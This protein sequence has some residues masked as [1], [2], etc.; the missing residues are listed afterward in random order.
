[1]Y[2]P[3]SKIWCRYS[4]GCL[5]IILTVT[6]TSL[7]CVFLMAGGHIR[8]ILE[9]PCGSDWSIP[10]HRRSSFSENVEC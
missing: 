5:N 10:P 8:T 6:G 4:C 7:G 9:M 3:C 1:M 2:A